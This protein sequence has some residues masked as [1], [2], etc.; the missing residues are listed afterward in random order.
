MN[1]G[2]SKRRVAVCVICGQRPL[3]YRRRHHVGG[4]NHVA[5]FTMP[6]CE[7]HHDQLHALLRTAGI[8]LEN[9][10]DPFVRISRAMG[11]CL[12]ALW[13]LMQAQQE[14]RNKQ[15]KGPGNE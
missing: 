6:L 7:A 15:E 3:R 5:W 12:V 2:T 9:T 11:A 4:K 1:I 8:D 14:L 13:M 10:S